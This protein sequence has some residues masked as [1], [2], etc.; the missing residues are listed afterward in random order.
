MENR[1][2]IRGGQAGF[3]RLKALARSLAPSTVSLLDRVN[4][5]TGQDCLDLGCGGGD[6][7]L[8]LARR[9][10]P[11]GSV[12]GIDFDEVKLDLARGGRHPRRLVER[13]VQVGRC[14][15]L[16]RIVHV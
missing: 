12:V 11:S 2:V 3:N 9:V 1:Y 7:T 10:G 4:V 5:Q 14:A 16:G 15:N 6:V 8:E 13:D